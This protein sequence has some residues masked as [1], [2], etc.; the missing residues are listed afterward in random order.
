MLLTKVQA[1][2]YT[3]RVRARDTNAGQ[4]TSLA[5]HEAQAYD[6]LSKPI[7]SI[8]A[9][10]ETPLLIESGFGG[11]LVAQRL[12]LTPLHNRYYSSTPDSR[13]CRHLSSNKRRCTNSR[14]RCTWRK[15]KLRLKL[16]MTLRSVTTCGGIR[17]FTYALSD[18]G[19]SAAAGD[20]SANGV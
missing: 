14:C 1:K 9:D 17:S 8:A 12:R 5:H 3:S 10:E 11:T 18:A 13:A 15:L 19:I 2:R 16:R 20:R 7:L 6:C 4:S